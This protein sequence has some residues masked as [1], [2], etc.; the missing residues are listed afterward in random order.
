MERKQGKCKC[1]PVLYSFSVGKGNIDIR[2]G[3]NSGGKV[4][5]RKVNYMRGNISGL[6]GNVRT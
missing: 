4:K 2:D 5:R 6:K 1:F 3:I